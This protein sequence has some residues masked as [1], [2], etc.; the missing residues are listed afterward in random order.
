MNLN[1]EQILQV[2]KGRLLNKVKSFESSANFICINSREC[3]CG[4]L[5]AAFKGHKTDGTNYISSAIE[6]GCSIVI[7][8]SKPK[9]KD[10]ELASEKDI[11]IIFVESSLDAV[12]KI[13]KFWRQQIKSTVIG[14]TGSTGKTS[15]KEL[16][17]SVLKTKYSVVGTKGNNN[18]ELGV[19]IT[20]SSCN[21]DTGFAVCEM[22]MRGKGEIDFLSNIARPDTA[23]ITNIGTSHIER[24]GSMENIANAKFE[25]INY[26]KSGSGGL[27]L[28][29]KDKFNDVVLKKI[30]DKKVNLKIVY[31][32]GDKEVSNNCDIQV[33][34]DNVVID[35]FCYPSFC[36]HVKTW[37][38]H[39]GVF[40][41]ESANVELKLSGYHNISNAC[42]AIAI[43]RLYNIP[44]NN[45]ICAISK[46]T[47]QSGRAKN[48][49]L[50]ND[51]KLID[52]AYNSN[53]ESCLSSVKTFDLMKS[54]YRKILVLGDMAELGEYAQKE[55]KKIGEYIARSSIDKLICV[56]LLA[57]EFGT[58]AASLG[59]KKDDIFY[60]NN[61]NEAFV[62][63]Q[64]MLKSRDM[65][66]VKG[67]N[68]TNLT[69]LVKKLI[70]N[71][72]N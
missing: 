25:I 41:Y 69:L 17:L 18:N 27:L 48:I 12:Q 50:K 68:C 52:D 47:P 72:E 36:V 60:T 14:I 7:C 59:F 2:T 70:K 16:I 55:H 15:T 39:N 46:V 38:E 53:P 19:P 57:K 62:L 33:W 13:A 42:S 35:E 40:N 11:P 20:L 22:G 24:L 8:E 54:D 28:N 37:D 34:A 30:N 61:Y 45:C 44:L 29:A 65:V 9:I 64:K 6:N 31:F 58:S 3:K 21:V 5:F 63:L 4:N 49:N 32:G 43:G 71:F 26:M 66:L 23:V 56:G 1:T 67:S 51:I 10:L